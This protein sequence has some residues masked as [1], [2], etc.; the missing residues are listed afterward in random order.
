MKHTVKKKTRWNALDK[1]FSTEQ[2]KIEQKLKLSV[3]ETINLKR[4]LQKF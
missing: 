2:A 1:R 3:N 4:A